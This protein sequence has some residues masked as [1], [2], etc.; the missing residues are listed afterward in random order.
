MDAKN[1]STRQYSLYPIEV[2]DVKSS[3]EFCSSINNQFTANQ[4]CSGDCHCIVP[5]Y[6]CPNESSCTLT[7]AYFNRSMGDKG[8]GFLRI[9][10]NGDMARDSMR[11]LG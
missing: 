2:C 9:R 4:D 3:F 7:T 5:L 10:R 8:Q 11:L 1:K 6:D